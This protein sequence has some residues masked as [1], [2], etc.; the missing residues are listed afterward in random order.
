MNAATVYY[1]SFGMK[2]IKSVPQIPKIQEAFL[3][4]IILKRLS[5]IYL[6]AERATATPSLLYR[7]QS[8]VALFEEMSWK[9]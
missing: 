3:V 1:Q 2:S 8:V 7:L 4:A 6:A 5:N 9:I